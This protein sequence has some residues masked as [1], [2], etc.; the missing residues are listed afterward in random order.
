VNLELLE[1]ENVFQ[2]EGPEKHKSRDQFCRLF[3]PI[4][5]EHYPY[6]LIFKEKQFH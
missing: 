3:E 6:L 2:V 5:D 1:E 4:I